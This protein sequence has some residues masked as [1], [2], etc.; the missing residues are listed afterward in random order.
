MGA[1]A[2][3]QTVDAGEE[4][5]VDDAFIAEGGDFV[6]ALEA[7]LVDLVLLGADEGAFVDVGVDFDVGVVGELE[8][9]PFAVVDYHYLR[10]WGCRIEAKERWGICYNY[11]G[12]QW[13]CTVCPGNDLKAECSRTMSWL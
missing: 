1:Q 5:I 4:A 9:V 7:G 13:G 2:G 10:V 6:L 11:K 3:E 8:G 12:G